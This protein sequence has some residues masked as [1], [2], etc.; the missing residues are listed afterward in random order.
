MKSVMLGNRNP[1]RESFACENLS[2]SL[3]LA[4]PIDFTVMQY[5]N[6]VK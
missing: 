2:H 5:N 3:F 4:V 1:R 6:Y